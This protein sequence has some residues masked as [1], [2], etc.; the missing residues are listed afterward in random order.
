MITKKSITS[1][2]IDELISLRWSPRAFDISK[3][4]SREQM[5]SLAEAARWAPSCFNDQP[6][7]FIFWNKDLDAD[8]FAKAYDCVNEW[9]QKWVKNVPVLVAAFASNAFKHNKKENRWGGYDTGAACENLCLQAVSLGLV[10][11]QME[12]GRASCRERV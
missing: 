3:P 9:N 1:V 11:H 4:V 7:I 6:Y 8:H 12:I 10:A 2:D 5:K